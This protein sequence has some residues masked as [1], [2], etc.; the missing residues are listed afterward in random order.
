MNNAKYRVIPVG[1]GYLLCEYNEFTHTYQHVFFE[2]GKE[3]IFKTGADANK[4][5]DELF[6]EETVMSVEKEIR[7]EL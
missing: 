7:V 5:V 3:A 1:Y 4:Y 2:N 6:R